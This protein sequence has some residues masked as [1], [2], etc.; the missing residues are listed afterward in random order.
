MLNLL[1]FSRNFYFNPLFLK[2]KNYFNLWYYYVNLFIISNP[3]FTYLILFILIYLLTLVFTGNIVYCAD[4]P[5]DETPILANSPNMPTSSN[6]I[7]PS[8][9][10]T[11][12]ENTE[13]SPSNSSIS[14]PTIMS[15]EIFNNLGKASILAAGL[16]GIYKIIGVIP[17]NQ[18]G[19]VSIITT[20]LMFGSFT[21]INIGESF[22]KYRNNPTKA[23]ELERLK[24]LSMESKISLGDKSLKIGVNKDNIS[25]S[26]ESSNIDGLGISSP[27]LGDHIPPFYSPDSKDYWISSVLEENSMV[28]LSNNPYLQ[29]QYL[30]LFFACIS[31]LCVF[32][33]IFAFLMNKYGESLKKYFNNKIILNLINANQISSKVLSTVW[34]LLI[35]FS[36]MLIIISCILLIYNY[37]LYC[38]QP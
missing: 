7:K 14:I 13:S 16:T 4:K 10:A 17:L 24:D 22:F 33:Y 3:L 38:L 32:G 12:P 15:M 21:L 11:T 1:F 26:N 20:G 30:T 19:A 27:N 9:E 5:Q 25:I 29:L 18:R 8:T 2:L 31:L 37:D 28:N 36:N 34:L 23:I 6:S 35:L